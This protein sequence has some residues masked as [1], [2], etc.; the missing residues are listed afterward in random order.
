MLITFLFP[1]DWQRM[2]NPENVW[3]IF[4][5]KSQRLAYEQGKKDAIVVAEKMETFRQFEAEWHLPD[6][7]IVVRNK[8]PISLFDSCVKT[9]NKNVACKTDI[10]KLMLPSVIK[11]HISNVYTY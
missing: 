7:H 10:H 5:S 2:A 6:L 3:P 4:L 8:K 9:I 11:T 1:T